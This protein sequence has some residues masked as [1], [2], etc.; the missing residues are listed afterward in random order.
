MSNLTL[1]LNVIF[2]LIGIVAS[3]PIFRNI[4]RI[5][6]YYI[7][8]WLSPV[9]QIEIRRIHNG[10]LVGKPVTVDLSAKAPLVRQLRMAREKNNVRTDS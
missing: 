10:K 5:I 2:A 7:S 4:G 9:H 8:R 1:L 6:G 3:Y